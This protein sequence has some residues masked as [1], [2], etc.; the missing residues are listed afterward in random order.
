MKVYILECRDGD[1]GIA[2]GAY[3]TKGRSLAALRHAVGKKRFSSFQIE[4]Q[5]SNPDWLQ[6]H[7]PD[8][9]ENGTYYA[10][11]AKKLDRHA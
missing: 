1:G 5:P 9:N 11:H 7:D 8:Q 6:F 2:I 4:S 10:L 3:S